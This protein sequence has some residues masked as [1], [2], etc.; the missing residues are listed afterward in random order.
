MPSLPER[1][2]TRDQLDPDPLVQFG[3]WFED[4][5][6]AESV[7]PEAMAL[8]TA[9]PDGAPSVRMVLLKMFDERGFVFFTN[10]ASR[11]G[12]ELLSNPRAALLFHWK[13]LGR[14]IRI[15]GPVTRVSREETTEY[16]RRRTRGSQLGA[17]VSPQSRVIPDRDWL[18]R[19]VAEVER[20]HSEGEL[21]V[22]DEWGG[23]RLVPH[24]YEFWQ[25][26]LDRLH[27]RFRYEPDGDAWKADR[28]GP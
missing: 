5:R 26:G 24:A 25:H 13:P 14:Q 9:S 20:E 16:A 8:A 15:E 3:R 17:L 23:F 27:D 6:A 10:Y 1:P 11:K 4:A 12:G 21:P 7:D 22:S 2:L 19:R 28:L 18:E